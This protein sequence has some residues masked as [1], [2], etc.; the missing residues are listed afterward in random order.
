[1]FLNHKLHPMKAHLTLNSSSTQLNLTCKLVTASAT[2]FNAEIIEEVNCLTKIS[3]IVLHVR[4]AERLAKKHRELSN[5]E[6]F[7]A[8]KISKYESYLALRVIQ[9]TWTS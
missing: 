8:L 1:M 4:I 3:F 7:R 2:Y 9:T 6:C 5:F